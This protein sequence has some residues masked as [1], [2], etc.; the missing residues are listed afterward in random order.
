MAGFYTCWEVSPQVSPQMA[1]CLYFNDILGRTPF[2]NLIVA[3]PSLD[4]VEQ[5]LRVIANYCGD[6]Y[7][8]KVEVR[9]SKGSK[10]N[11]YHS[12]KSKNL[13]SGSPKRQVTPRIWYAG[14]YTT[15]STQDHALDA[16]VL[17]ILICL[18]N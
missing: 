7:V 11:V 2:L 3:F 6:A 17:D 1:S 15:F 14:M 12:P 13:Q 5:R 4:R 10:Q 8:I 18:M 16:R 9:K